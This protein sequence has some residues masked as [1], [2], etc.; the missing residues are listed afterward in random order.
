MER[1]STNASERSPASPGI[2]DGQEDP[3]LEVVAAMLGTLRKSIV[4][5]YLRNRAKSAA[6][7]AASNCER[8]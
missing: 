1:Q 6:K 5:V 7:Q 3:Q 4:S 2:G 8:Q